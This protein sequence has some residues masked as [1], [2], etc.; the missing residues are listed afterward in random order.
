MTTYTGTSYD[1]ELVGTSRG[2]WFYGMAGDDTIYGGNGD[3]FINGGSGLDIAEF[4]G[5]DNWINLNK[6]GYQNTGDGR[7]KLVSIEAIYAGDGD[8]TLI[9]H[10]RNSNFLAGGDG[11]DWIEAGKHSKDYLVGGAGIDTFE[12]RKGRGHA[13]IFDYENQ[14]W[15]FI[16]AKFKQV[17]YDTSGRDLQLFIRDD[18]VANFE[19]MAGKELWNDGGKWWYLE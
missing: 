12:L 11:D 18:L 7:D 19:G 8:D 1:D 5:N 14:D 10:R 13:E 2:E 15:I 6:K 17:T 9:G 16:N 3:D 4:S